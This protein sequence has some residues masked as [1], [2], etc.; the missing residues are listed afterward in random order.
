MVEVHVSHDPQKR[1]Q[2][3]WRL[4]FSGGFCPSHL[5]DDLLDEDDADVDAAGDV[6]Q[7]FWDEVVGGA[8]AH[9]VA[10]RAAVYCRFVRSPG[11]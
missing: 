5:V 10:T 7:E 9:P 4:G 3:P 8:S 6:G 1:R 11:T 2:G